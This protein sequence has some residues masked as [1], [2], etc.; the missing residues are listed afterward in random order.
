MYNEQSKNESFA[1]YVSHRRVRAA[2]IKTIYSPTCVGVEPYGYSVSFEP[3]GK[4]TPAVGWY[5]IAYEDGYISFCPPEQFEK[6]YRAVAPAASPE[7]KVSLE[8]AQAGCGLR[9]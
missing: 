2:K 5:V 6:G 4:P 8:D 1:D 7:P 9:R 3:K